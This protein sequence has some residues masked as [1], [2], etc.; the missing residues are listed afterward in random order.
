[1]SRPLEDLRRSAAG[2]SEAPPAAAAYLDKV[3]RRAYAITNADVDALRAAGMSEDEIF[4]QTI[5][6]AIREGIRRHDAAM[7]AIR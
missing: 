1:M 6:A 3:H 5:A 2:V 4:E 7:R